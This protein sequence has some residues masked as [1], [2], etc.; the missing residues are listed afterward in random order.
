MQKVV[1]NCGSHK[2]PLNKLKERMFRELNVSARAELVARL[3]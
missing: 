1:P 3:Q 2:I